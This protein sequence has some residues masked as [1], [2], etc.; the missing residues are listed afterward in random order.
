MAS[1]ICLRLFEQL[2]RAAASRTFCTAGRRRP[3]RMAMMAITTSSSISVNPVRRL[4]TGEEAIRTSAT[5][6]KR[7]LPSVAEPP[8]A[9]NTG[10]AVLSSG[11][12]RRS[13]RFGAA[14]PGPDADAVLQRQDEDL[15][16]PD[17]PLRAGPGGLDDGVHRRLDEVL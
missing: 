16:V 7:T 9:V 15:P 11:Q 13:D 3:I 10:A 5:E 6:R 12:V 8:T 2:D 4:V 14:L 17:P 1:P